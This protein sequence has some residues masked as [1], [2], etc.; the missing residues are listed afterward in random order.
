MVDLK[1]PDKLS[2]CTYLISYYNYFKDKPTKGIPSEADQDRPVEDIPPLKRVK[3]D[4]V[5]APSLKS[6][7]EEPPKPLPTKPNSPLLPPKTLGAKQTPPP[8]PPSTSKPSFSPSVPAKVPLA[9]S[10]SV[11]SQPKP[12]PPK[13]TEPSS[14]G[15]ARANAVSKVADLLGN[16]QK[17][18]L[19]Q[20]H[21]G[22]QVRP[23]AA[24]PPKPPR[25]A[26]VAMSSPSLLTQ[27]SSPQLTAST[28]LVNTKTTNKPALENKPLPITPPR[29]VDTAQTTDKP[30]PESKAL[31]LTPPRVPVDT[32]R[33][34]QSKFTKPQP[35]TAQEETSR[36]PQP[37]AIKRIKEDDLGTPKVHVSDKERKEEDKTMVAMPQVP[38][39]S[40]V[41]VVIMALFLVLYLWLAL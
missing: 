33:P 29:P 31:P 37:A 34:R 8:P 17:K 9:K 26:S 20:G 14:N 15:E 13:P 36:P 4:P 27:R 38:F 40:A 10:M 24:I 16:M 41:L 6:L 12:L 3:P 11:S 19:Q 39:G 22:V 35:S 18:E 28:N 1:V 25:P 2:I 21:G 30:V 32:A 7:P 23:R 5:S